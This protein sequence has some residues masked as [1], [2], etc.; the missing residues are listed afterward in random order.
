MKG[1]DLQGL[2]VDR[3]AGH[4]LYGA[5]KRKRDRTTGTLISD[6]DYF[7]TLASIEL[8]RANR[9]VVARHRVRVGMEVVDNET[10]ASRAGEASDTRKAQVDAVG[11]AAVSARNGGT[12]VD[13][14]VGLQVVGERHFATQVIERETAGDTDL[15]EGGDF[16]RGYI[17]TD[18]DRSGGD[19]HNAGDGDRD[20]DFAECK[21]GG[22]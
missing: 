4:R 22:A 18:E 21:R 19:Q 12:L 13:K 14:I 10:C 1:R 17:A 2:D 15:V 7:C 8:R 16:L 6:R 9:H 20:E 5:C 11:E 3:G